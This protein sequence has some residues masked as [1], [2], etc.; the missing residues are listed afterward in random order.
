MRVETQ[1]LQ[2][3]KAELR[4]QLVH[5]FCVPVESPNSQIITFKL[6]QLYTKIQSIQGPTESQS[7][8][9]CLLGITILGTPLMFLSSQTC[10]GFWH[11]QLCNDLFQ[12]THSGVP[13]SCDW[14]SVGGGDFFVKLPKSCRTLLFTNKKTNHQSCNS[15]CVT[16]LS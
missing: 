8:Y 6:I 12:E 4:K 13:R 14:Q 9:Q 11:A 3:L 1:H 7:I 15:L 16:Q 5:N 10:G 2:P